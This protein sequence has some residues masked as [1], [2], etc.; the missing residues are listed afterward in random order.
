MVFTLGL[1]EGGFGGGVGG[2]SGCK[3]VLDGWVE[4][5]PAE[6]VM[7]SPPPEAPPVDWLVASPPVFPGGISSTTAI[8]KF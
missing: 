7:L 4:E 3:N 8:L 5:A 2:T 1:V 6:V